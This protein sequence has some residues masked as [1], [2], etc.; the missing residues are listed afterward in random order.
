MTPQYIASAADLAPLTQDVI[1]RGRL[2]QTFPLDLGQIGALMFRHVALREA[3]DGDGDVL[4]AVARGGT[5]LACDLV[6]SATRVKGL[7]AN[8]TGIEQGRL[9]AAS[10]DMTFPENAEEL[11]DFLAQLRALADRAKAAQP[12]LK[13]D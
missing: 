1:V 9:I 5:L 7:G 2:V 6:D 11:A 3:F 13:R 4:A 10:L 8:L 12:L